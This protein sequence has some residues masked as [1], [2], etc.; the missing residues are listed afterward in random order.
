MYLGP[1]GYTL[2]KSKISI[3][4][5]EKIKKELTVSPFVPKS[6]LAEASPFPIF[7]ESLEKLYLPK[8]YGIEKFGNT[9]NIKL[10]DGIDINLDFN[11]TLRPFQDNIVN[12]YVDIA[13][14]SGGG[15]LDVYTGAGKT[16]MAL[17]IISKMKKKTLIIVHKEFLVN[18]WIERIEQ[19]LPG[20]RIGKIQGQI[21]DVDDKDI[22]L[23]MLQ[24]LSM[25]E[26][27]A[28][29]FGDNFGLTILDE[30]FTFD[31]GIITEN[32]VEYIGTLFEKWKN[33][34]ETPKILSYNQKQKT[35]EYKNMTYSWR[36]IK[37][38]LIKIKM[39]KKVLKCT[40]EHKIM[41]MNGYVPANQLK[42][43][44]LILCKYD[45]EH[46]DSII[47]K[48]LNEDQKQIVYGSYLGDGHISHTNKQRTRLR[49]IHGEKQIEY[50]RWK[51]NMFDINK[52]NYI[53]KAGYSNTSFYNFNTKIFDLE[54]EI[55][56]NTKIVPDWLIEKI[57]LR[58]IAIWYMDDGSINKNKLKDGSISSY[59]TI[60]S[61]NFDYEIHEKFVKKFNK[62]GID[63]TICKSKGKYYY[64]RFNKE[65][66]SK[67]LELITPYIPENMEYKIN[68]REDKYLW[69]NKFLNYGSLKINKIE[70]IENKGYG[71]C[72]TPYVYDIEVADNHNFVIA[73]KIKNSK[74]KNYLD[75][76]VVS[77]CHHIAAEVFSRALFKI[78]TKHMLGLSAT[79]NRKD[80]LSSVFKMFI[81][82]IF[83]KEVR[84]GEDKVLVKKILYDTTD[85]EFNQTILNYR[86]QV[87]YSMMI[88]KI[89]EYSFRT[90]FILTVIQKILKENNEQQIMILAHNKSILNYLFKAIESRNIDSVGYYLGGM[91]EKDLKISET[92]KI[93]IATYAMAE[94]ALD[95]KTLTTLILASPKTDVTQAVG[96]ILRIKHDN[97]LVIDIVDMHDIFQRQWIKRQKFYI[98]QKYEI[99]SIKNT[100]FLTD[101]YETIYNPDK[102]NKIKKD[103]NE[104]DKIED[105]G[106]CIVNF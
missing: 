12:K 80:G 34:K 61:N 63:C 91:K 37:K 52:L 74:D 11:G 69:N 103:K 60:H 4:E 33:N 27:P 50:C 96:R 71:R 55:P 26:Y 92:K 68:E 15:L 70:Y 32:G 6:S 17:N 105:L 31:T 83:H 85:P 24:S 5:Q 72:S 9:D 97:P 51:A 81:G 77:N 102:S 38:D 76:I 49:I 82:P 1:K 41:T 7:R 99:I 90:E 3:V 79:M 23:G 16:V 40:P 67:L 19:F 20:A 93:V 30:C 78:V 95:I 44:D 101:N 48:C 104:K 58:G 53:E 8:Y 46:Q 47:A 54:D 25:K 106:K 98:K 28:S 65:N 64:L 18:Q 10:K 88:K 56:K 86:G 66:T 100:E 87:H 94:E 36:K 2:L 59:I 75:G 57:D 84:K 35:F 29:L 45:T 43:N 13:N 21:V 62:Y 22:V 14:K 42:I 73:T 39:S 89:C